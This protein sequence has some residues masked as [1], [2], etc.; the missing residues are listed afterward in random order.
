MIVIQLLQHG[1]DDVKQLV[2]GCLGSYFG[3]VNSVE[4]IPI[5][6]LGY[7]GSIVEVV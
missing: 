7:E 5:N 1:R 4:Q 2:I 3:T 6:L